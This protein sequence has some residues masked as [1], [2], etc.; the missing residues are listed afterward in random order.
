MLMKKGAFEEALDCLLRSFD[1]AREDGSDVA[2]AA[3]FKVQ[4]YHMLN[5]LLA[6]GFSMVEYNSKS[7]FT[8]SKSLKNQ[9]LIEVN[10]NALS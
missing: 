7:K 9:A 1:L 4:E 10:V 6:S 5:S 8:L 3:R 2:D